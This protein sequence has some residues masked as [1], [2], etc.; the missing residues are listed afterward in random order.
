MSKTLE[1]L[2]NKLHI[3]DHVICIEQQDDFPTANKTGIIVGKQ[4]TQLAIIFDEPVNG[5]TFSQG[6][7]LPIKHYQ[8]AIKNN[9]KFK[10]DHGLWCNENIIKPLNNKTKLQ[11]SMLK[12][13]K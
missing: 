13:I 7:S 8:I 11:A 9:I 6:F 10:E 1:K 12:N 3:L 4:D 2:T 5:H